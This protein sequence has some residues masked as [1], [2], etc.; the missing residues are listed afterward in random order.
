MSQNETLTLTFK[1]QLNLIQEEHR[2]TVDA[3]RNQLDAAELEI[4]RLHASRVAAAANSTTAVVRMS[5]DPRDMTADR[6]TDY[7][8]EHRVEE[9]QSGEGSE[10]IDDE[11]ASVQSKLNGNGSQ[12]SFIPFEQLLSSQLSED[13]ASIRTIESEETTV[14]SSLAA[15]EKQIEHLTVLLNESEATVL[16]LTEQ[17]SVLKGE[18]R[19][20][21]RNQERENA[22]SNMEYLKN[23]VYKF[24]TLKGGNERTQLV[25]VLTTMLKFSPEEKEQLV[26]M[27]SGTEAS[28]ANAGDVLGGL[29]LYMNRWSGFV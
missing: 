25:P 21:E 12:S 14:R 28:G 15:S 5:P 9:R 8:R 26:Q 3:L 4:D 29:G 19:R 2:Q 23:I 7:P 13:T 20:L 11:V 18:I 24:L 17:A 27:A 10:N 1:E 22:I 6:V 16:R